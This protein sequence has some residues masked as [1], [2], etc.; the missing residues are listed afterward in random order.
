MTYIN[1]NQ[2]S[3]KVVTLFVSSACNTLFAS[4]IDLAMACTDARAT[5][6]ILRM[7]AET[8]SVEFELHVLFMYCYMPR[9]IRL[10]N[11]FFCFT[12]CFCNL[13]LVFLTSQS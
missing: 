2:C 8:M 10:C 3:V 11:S 12:G 5:V 7:D 9:S 6:M 4:S 13:L 1:L